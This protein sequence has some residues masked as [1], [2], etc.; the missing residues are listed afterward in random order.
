MTA[1]RASTPAPA[2]VRPIHVRGADK[3]FEPNPT[4]RSLPPRTW[5]ATEYLARHGG[6]DEAFAQNGDAV[7]ALGYRECLWRLAA[8]WADVLGIPNQLRHAELFV[9]RSVIWKGALASMRPPA[10]YPV[11]STWMPRLWI[12]EGGIETTNGVMHWLLWFDSTL[13]YRLNSQ[14]LVDD[15]N[16][17]VIAKLRDPRDDELSLACIV[18]NAFLESPYVPRTSRGVPRQV[19]KAFKK[20]TGVDLAPVTFVNLRAVKRESGQEPSGV[21]DIIEWTCRWLVRGHLR[22]QWYPSENTHRLIWVPPHLKGPDGLPLK[23]TVY[24][25][26]R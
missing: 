18:L 14:S 8:K 11:A 20:Q 19:R 6:L 25:V 4:P 7:D 24:R 5:L 17:F 22:N 2:S 9:W 13:V 3:I 10:Q 21:N 23:E 15:R 1:A 16:V 26:T 12:F